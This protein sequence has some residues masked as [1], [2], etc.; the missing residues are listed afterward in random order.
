MQAKIYNDDLPPD[1][2]ALLDRL[3][4]MMREGSPGEWQ[5]KLGRR[6]GLPLTMG[7][8]DQCMEEYDVMHRVGEEQEGYYLQIESEDPRRGRRMM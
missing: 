1:A 6:L 5:T 2:E 8:L 3:A 7:S 4:E